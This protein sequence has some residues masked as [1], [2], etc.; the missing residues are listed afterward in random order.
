MI[1]NGRNG[2][3]VVEE[4]LENCTYDCFKRGHLLN[5]TVIEYSS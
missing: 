2:R 5:S 3:I 1:K 4:K